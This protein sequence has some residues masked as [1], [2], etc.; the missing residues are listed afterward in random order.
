MLTDRTTGIKKPSD[1]HQCELAVDIL[2]I[3]IANGHCS[4]TKLVICMR[5]YVYKCII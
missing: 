4:I 3:K 1:Q 5:V 2:W